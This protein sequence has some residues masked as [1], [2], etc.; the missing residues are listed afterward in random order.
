MTKNKLD[1]I[2]KSYDIRG[3]FGDSIDQDTVYKI[4]KAFAEF[5]TGD[6]I[7][8]GHDG[9]ISNIKMLDAFKTNHSSLARCNCLISKK[10]KNTYVGETT[11]PFFSDCTSN[12]LCAI[13]K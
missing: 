2:F 13:F 9:R 1:L 5:I 7:I 11:N 10:T 8:I 12:S 4:G 6:T 3:I